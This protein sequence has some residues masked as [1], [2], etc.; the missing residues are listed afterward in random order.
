M[1]LVRTMGLEPTQV[2]LL[3]P[4]DSVSAIPPRPL[5][6]NIIASFLLVVKF[7]EII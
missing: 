1:G 5:H 2:S 6:K 3:P 7:F 4:E